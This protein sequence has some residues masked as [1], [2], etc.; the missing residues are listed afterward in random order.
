M[1]WKRKLASRKFWVCVCGFVTAMMTACRMS[2]EAARVTAVV[3]AFG[4]LISYILA[5]GLVDAAAADNAAADTASADTS[6]AGSAAQTQTGGTA[7]AAQTE[8]K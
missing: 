4:T 2:G 5:E 8:G 1:D 7:A 3:M 6:A